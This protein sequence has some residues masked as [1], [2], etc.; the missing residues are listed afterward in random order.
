MSK[1]RELKEKRSTVVANIQKMQEQ[2]DGKTMDA[3]AR[4]A[5][6]K[7]VA[8]ERE[9]KSQIE[10]EERRLALDGMVAN[11]KETDHR[12]ADEKKLETRAFVKFLLGQELTAEEKNVQR[13]A[14]SGTNGSVLVP[15][16]VAPYIESALNG[17]SGLMQAA[18]VIRTTAGG[19][20]VWPTINNATSKAKVMAQYEQSAKAA[21]TFSS[22]TL[23]AYTYRTDIVPVS[24]ELLQDS[25]FNIEQYI[26]ELLAKELVDGLNAD[27]TNGTGTNAPKGIAKDAKSVSAAG[28]G[29]AYDDV[30][31][32]MK[33]VPS[34]Y[35]GA[36]KFMMN[37]KTMYDLALIKDAAERPI[38]TPAMSAAMPATI[39][40]KEIVLNDDLADN[41]IVYGDLKKY[42][43]RMVKDYSVAVLRE[44]LMEYLSIG[45]IGYCRADGVLLDAGTNPVAILTPGA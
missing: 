40:G 37:A 28:A 30:I 15:A 38:W 36:A 18:D 3:E 10:S 41:A 8:E 13:R 35:Q 45:I 4:A 7:M 24:L 33:A 6:D 23:K 17:M 12:S 9:L 11:Q 27:F 2:Y 26:G 22:K 1:L 39:F 43:I 14:I 16:G 32:L 29:V 31:A 21:K 5:W 34:A 20:L 44:A 42:K 19:D 25:A